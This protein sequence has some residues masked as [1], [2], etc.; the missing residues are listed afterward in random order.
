MGRFANFWIGRACPL[1]VIIKRLKPLTALSGT[2]Y[3]LASSLSD[4][5]PVS[6]SVFEDW[7][8]ESVV[9]HISFDSIRIRFERKRPIRRSLVLSGIYDRLD[10]NRNA[11]F[12]S[13]FRFERKRLIRRSLVDWVPNACV[14]VCW[15]VKSENVETMF[16]FSVSSY[17]S[18]KNLWKSCVEYHT[19]L[20]SRQCKQT[21]TAWMT[22]GQKQDVLDLRYRSVG[23]SLFVCCKPPPLELHLAISELWFGPEWEGILLE[24]LC[25]SSIV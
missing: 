8:E 18:C 6:F 25:S 2:V 21:T 13:R 14:C 23:L 16:S 20:C 4:R 9:P 12:D 7:N 24:L 3:R 11:R 22:D 5:T 17:R 10:S 15:R 19:F 1:L